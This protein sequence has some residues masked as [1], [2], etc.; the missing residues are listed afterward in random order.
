MRWSRRSPPPGE[1]GPVV[2]EARALLDGT[3]R[4]QRYP[5]WRRPPAWVYL[6]ELAHADAET[7][8][9]LAESRG[10][11][12]PAT[13]EYAS[14]FLAAEILARANETG[15]LLDIQRSLVPLELDLLAAYPAPTTAASFVALAL[16]A[17]A[18]SG[19][20]PGL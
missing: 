18:A 10:K 14:A 1:D 8:A 13:F 7:L 19:S 20:S 16:H 5:A 12:H 4:A 2:S 17:L 11:V 3:V 9:R 6:N 15:S